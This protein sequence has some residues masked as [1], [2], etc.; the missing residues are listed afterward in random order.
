MYTVSTSL[1]PD[2]PR[3][4][5]R[6]KDSFQ[7]ESALRVIDIIEKDTGDASL[8]NSLYFSTGVVDRIER[9]FSLGEHII[10]DSNLVGS[11]IDY[12]L[13][14]GLPVQLSC[15]IDDPSVVSFATQKRI[16]RA[17]IAVEHAL[18]LR[19]P[20]LIVVGSAPMALSRLLQINQRATLHEVVIIAAASGFANVVELKERLWESGLPCIVARGRR[21]G[22]GAAI[23]ITNALLADAVA[24]RP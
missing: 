3:S 6:N 18:S 11:G 16:T 20:K 13:A 7:S 12:D 21:G 14:A 19:G 1:R 23:A 4:R 15:F 5:R 8:R 22:A 17:E 2:Q 10:V 24:H 9:E